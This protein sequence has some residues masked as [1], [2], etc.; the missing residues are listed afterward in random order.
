ME[1]NGRNKRI[2]ILQIICIVCVATLL[3]TG[4]FGSGV[5]RLINRANGMLSQDKPVSSNEKPSETNAGSEKIVYVAGVIRNS[6]D[7]WQLIE[8]D[9]HAPLNC[10]S[11][12]V[13]ESKGSISINY[14][15]L[16]IKKVITFTVTPD[17]T[18]SSMGYTCGAS[19]GIDHTDVY[20]YREKLG[21]ILEKNPNKVVSSNGN[22]W[23]SGMFEIE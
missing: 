5:G 22:L 15:D 6:G 12:S 18:L 4:I 10:K 9:K 13:N 23:F 14:S 7:G 20:I 8:D 3:I 21:I 17:E 19:V 16:N 2:I 11:V 1:N